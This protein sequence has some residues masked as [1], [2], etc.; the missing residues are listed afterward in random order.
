MRKM[1]DK[2]PEMLRKKI[3]KAAKITIRKPEGKKALDYLRDVRRFSDAVIDKFDVGYC[4]DDLDN[5][6]RGR[7]ITPIYDTYGEMVAI[8]TRHMNRDLKNRFWHES[9]DKGSYLYGLYCAKNMARKI[10]KII[11]VEG[12]FDALAFHS[13]G[14]TMTV[15]CCGSAF[16]LF[17]VSLLSR[18]CTEFYFL[19]DGDTAGRKSTQR[20]M[21]MYNK[22]NLSAYGLNFIPVYLPKNTDPDEFL[23]ENGIEG[24]KEKLKVARDD[25]EFI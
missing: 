23:F 4:P 9:F 3:V 7:I 8:S 17:H 20:A 14:F 6:L 18:Y 24:V 2:Y 25:H 1:P 19:F 5:E 10:N 22:Y 15:C 12:E 16:T 11:I 21:D 13:F